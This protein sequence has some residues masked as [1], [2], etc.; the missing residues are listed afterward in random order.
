[1][2]IQ[3]KDIW[4]PVINIM[5]CPAF[6]VRIRRRTRLKIVQAG[7]CLEYFEVLRM[8][9]QSW[10][11]FST[12]SYWEKLREMATEQ[13][14][15]SK[16][17]RWTSRRNTSRRRASQGKVSLWRGQVVEGQVGDGQVGDGQVREGQV[18]PPDSYQAHVFCSYGSSV[19]L[20]PLPHL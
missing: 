19:P 11:T 1:M 7:S 9:A 3:L 5:V 15:K 14:K 6:L 17:Q 20:F 10:R 18:G 12:N 13:L 2:A 16:S 4:P 8:S